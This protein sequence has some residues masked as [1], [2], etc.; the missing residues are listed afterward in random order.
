MFQPWS[1]GHRS[2][3]TFSAYAEV[4]ARPKPFNIIMQQLLT[5]AGAEMINRLTRIV[6]A[7]ALAWA[8]S[9]LEFGL[10]AIALTAND[11]L[12]ALTQTGIGA[13]IITTRDSDLADTCNTAY[14]LNWW[15][16][17]LVAVLQTAIAF[18]VASHFGDMRIAWLLCALALPYWLYP[19]VAVQVYRVQ[20]QSRMRETALMLLVLITGDN[21]LTALFA[22]LGG[23]LMSLA[24]PKLICAALW[25]VI[26]RRLE[27]WKPDSTCDNSQTL[28]TLRFGLGVLLSEILQVLR[29][30]ADKLVVG[31]VLGLTVLGQYFFAFNAG[32]G[33]SSALLTV[34]STAL[35]P[36]YSKS[37]ASSHPARRF[38]SGTLLLYIFLLPLIGLQIV[39]APYYVPFVFGAKWAG[40]VHILVLLCTCAIPLVLSRSTSMFLRSRNR[41]S[42][43]LKA[44]TCHFAFGILVLLFCINRGLEA[45]II[46]QCMATALVAAFFSLVAYYSTGGQND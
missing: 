10:A 13:R 43:E 11:I 7:M 15:A 34:A 1:E 38:V 9:P 14:R 33:I 3:T 8:L 23:G 46:G 32:L 4:G 39:L 12:R 29:L 45:V 5:L 21:L 19:L 44:A 42:L 2:M 20:R 22:V 6:T 28:V 27:I 37:E 36:Y 40:S 26:Y 17:G 25:V 35:L 16:Y 41:I 18:P 31:H 24:L 30:H